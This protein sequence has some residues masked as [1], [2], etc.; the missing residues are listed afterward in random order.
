MVWSETSDTLVSICSISATSIPFAAL[1]QVEHK[2]HGGSDLCAKVH[3][4]ILAQQFQAC[5]GA[6]QG[7]LKNQGAQKQRV[8]A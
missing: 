1:G 4:E 6:A 2:G 3:V 5:V 7:I 8:L